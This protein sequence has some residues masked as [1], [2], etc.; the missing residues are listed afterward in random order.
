MEQVRLL[1]DAGKEILLEGPVNSITL[2][3]LNMDD[4][5]C[6]FRQPEK[7]KIALREIAA[8]TDGIVYIARTG[9]CIVGYVT[10]HRP[11]SF[12]RWSKHPRILELGAIEV[13]PLYRKHKLARRLLQMAFANPIMEDFIVITIEFCWHWDLDNTGLTIWEYQKMLT[14]LFGSVGLEKV[15]TDDPDILEHVAN[16]LMARI[17]NNVSQQDIEM[18]RAMQFMHTGMIR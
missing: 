4:K 3:D 11:D 14:K 5:L 13:S 8:S 10:F 7:Q 1:L 18:F 9:N 16:V 15:D 2:S 6:N 17:G 12:S